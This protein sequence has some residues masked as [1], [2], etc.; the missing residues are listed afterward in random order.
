MTSPTQSNTPQIQEKLSVCPLD[1]PDTCSLKVTVTDNEITK[2]RGSQVNPLTEGSICTK[3]ARYYPDFVHGPRR[4]RHPLLRTG[5]RGSGQYRQISW[6]EA[7]DRVHKGLSQAI[8]T[9][10]SASVLPF[11]YAGPHGQLS[12]GS[13]DVRFFKNWGHTAEPWP[14]LRRRTVSVLPLT[15]RQQ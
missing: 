15:L 7:L 5:P 6:D 12:G 2:I 14:A 10:G 13:M 9:H 4:L 8:E 3:V 11:N 1:C